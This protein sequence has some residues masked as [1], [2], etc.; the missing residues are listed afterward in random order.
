LLAERRQQDDPVVLGESVGDPPRS[1]P[2]REAQFE[3]PSP[4]TLEN[5]MRAIE[6]RSTS[7][8]MT[9]TARSHSVESK[10]AIHSTISSCNSI[11]A[12]DSLPHTRDDR[13][14]LWGATVVGNDVIP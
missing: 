2:E 4:S 10:L 12:T 14:A 9:M 13:M 6:P 11:P 8:S 1:R 5:D 7:R 3:E